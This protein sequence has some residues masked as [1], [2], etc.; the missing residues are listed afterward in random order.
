VIRYYAS[1]Q[2]GL[3]LPCSTVLSVN[4][5]FV[6]GTDQQSN[7]H[8]MLQDAGTTLLEKLTGHISAGTT[9]PRVGTILGAGANVS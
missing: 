3:V 8:N 9:V 5:T 4:S 2:V 1:G 6:S 7:E